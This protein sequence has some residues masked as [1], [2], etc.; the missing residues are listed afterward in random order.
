MNHN[1]MNYNNNN[2][3][4]NFN[5]NNSFNSMNHNNFSRDNNSYKGNNISKLENTRALI[6]EQNKKKLILSLVIGVIV[7]LIVAVL[8]VGFIKYNQKI[9]EN[10]TMIDGEYYDEVYNGTL[11]FDEYNLSDKFEFSLPLEFRNTKNDRNSMEF[12]LVL[13]DLNATVKLSAINNFTKEKDLSN[14]MAIHYKVPSPLEK[15][16]NGITWYNIR[17]IDVNNHSVNIANINDKLFMLEMVYDNAEAFAPY[18]NT[19]LY[20]IKIK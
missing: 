5:P 7:C 10:V 17:Y 1:S 6:K 19:I 4:N 20:G 8:L 18:E 12:S 15:K 9:H 16:I 3:N 14:T 13:E 11:V 2:F